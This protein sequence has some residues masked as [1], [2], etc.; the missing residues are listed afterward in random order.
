VTSHD[1]P[2]LEEVSESDFTERVRQIEIDP[3]LAA[4]AEERSRRR[5]RERA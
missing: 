4:H 2:T 5:T 1:A 3:T